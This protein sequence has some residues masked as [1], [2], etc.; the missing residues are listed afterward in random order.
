MVK[1]RA[2]ETAA[3]RSSGMSRRPSRLVACKI[4]VKLPDIWATRLSTSYP[5]AV[6]EILN[7]MDLDEKRCVAE[8]RIHSQDPGEVFG[9]LQSDSDMIEVELLDT[10][11]RT[12]DVRMVYKTPGFVDLFRKLTLMWRFPIVIKNGIGTWVV[13][14]PDK[15]LG[16]LM[17]AGKAQAFFAEAEAVYP[18]RV[19]GPNL[20]TPRQAYLFREAMAAGYFE[21]PRHITLTKLARQLKMAPS[22]LSEILAVVEKKLLLDLR[23][24]P[25]S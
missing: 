24:E 3:L 19:R 25:E 17:D 21:V 9:G 8:I 4:R 1:G 12:A 2:S 18:A 16:K 15:N 7:R 20:L 6:I 10:T 5:D 11:A 23:T 22:S 14:G 13:V